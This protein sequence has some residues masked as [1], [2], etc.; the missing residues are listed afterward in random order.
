MSQQFLRQS[1]DRRLGLE[2]NSFSD[3]R[4]TDAWDSSQLRLNPNSFSVGQW[5]DAWDLSRI[6][7]EPNSFT[8]GS[9]VAYFMLCD[10]FD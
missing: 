9:V 6:G 3:S 5:T 1:K 8:V 2:P 10:P 7:L 4:R